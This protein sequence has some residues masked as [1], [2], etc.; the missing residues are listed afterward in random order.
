MDNLLRRKDDRLGG[1][2][3]HPEFDSILELSWC[4][5]ER[6]EGKAY[7]PYREGVVAKHR[8]EQVANH[9]ALDNRPLQGHVCGASGPPRA[10]P[11]PFFSFYY[12]DFDLHRRRS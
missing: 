8:E 1:V 12:L 4:V 10:N 6:L 11:G 7:E 2:E 3:V 5:G 9:T